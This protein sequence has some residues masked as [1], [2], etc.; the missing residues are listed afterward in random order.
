MLE[1][2]HSTILVLIALMSTQP[3]FVFG[4]TPF[5]ANDALTKNGIEWCEENYSL[6]KLLGN[7]FFVHHKHSI[8][9]RVCASLYND[10]LWTYEGPDRIDRLVVKSQYYVQL[11]IQESQKEAETGVIDPTPATSP[12][13][14][15]EEEIVVSTPQESNE[16]ASDEQEVAKTTPEAGGCLIATATYGTELANEV[17]QLREVR[18][19]VVMKTEAGKSFLQY[20]NA[21]YYSFSPTIADWERES[22]VFKEIVKLFISPMIASLSILNFVDINSDSEIIIYGASIISLNIGIY[23]IAPFVATTKIKR[24]F[25]T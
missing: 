12:E 16:Q 23:I 17:Q 5:F 9:S 6:Y 13:I 14:Q 19:N 10:P 18:D 3:L 11:E 20:F 15:L 1:K 7:D 24:K 21:F 2:T 4:A 25:F 8:E 22:H